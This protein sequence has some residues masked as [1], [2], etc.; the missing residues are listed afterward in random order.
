MTWSN[1]TI[2][3][4][5]CV[6][7]K[8][9]KKVFFAWPGQTGLSCPVMK[10]ENGAGQSVLFQ[11]ITVNLTFYKTWTVKSLLKVLT[12]APNRFTKDTCGKQQ[13]QR[14][15]CLLGPTLLPPPHFPCTHTYSKV[16]LAREQHCMECACAGPLQ[17]SVQM[18]HVSMQTDKSVQL[19]V[20][21]TAATEAREGTWY[22]WQSI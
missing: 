2:L 1:R 20:M 15:T 17:L 6:P 22:K 10:E 4:T 11:T 19:P 8:K 16:R 3:P 9:G 13:L 18:L 7:P 12:A 21:I 5:G 14:R